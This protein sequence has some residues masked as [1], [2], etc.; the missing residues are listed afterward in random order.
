MGNKKK[1]TAER[2]LFKKIIHTALY[3]NTDLREL[4]LGDT[5]GKSAKELQDEFKA[6]VKS[7][8]F[9][10]DTLTEAESYIF[11]DVR[12][13][14]IHTHIKNC[15]VLLYAIC[16]RSILEGYAKEGYY[17][18]RSDILAQMVEDSL[19]NNP[20]IARSFGIGDIN[21]VGVDIYNSARYYGSILTFEVPNF[22]A[23][24]KN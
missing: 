21:L 16:H 6:H 9:I 1:T 4:L 20:S 8:L 13:P 19:I 22:R 23:T 18:N 11:Y 10:D 2:G 7:H 15:T 24:C 3:K 12:F 17:G 5:T 14:V